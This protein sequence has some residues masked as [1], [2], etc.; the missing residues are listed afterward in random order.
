MGMEAGRDGYISAGG[1][2]SRRLLPQRYPDDVLV[3]ADWVRDRLELFADPA[4]DY[5][6]LEVDLNTAFYD[7]GH[8]P[9]ALSVDWT[10]DLQAEHC[11]DLVGPEAFGRLLG[12][13]GITEDT[14]VVVYGDN[15]NWFATHFHWI[16]S[17]YRHADVRVMDGGR[18]YWLE[19]DY[20]TSEAVPTVPAVDYEVRGRDES[21]R[22]YRDDVREALDTDTVFIDVRMPEEYRGDLTA[23]PGYNEAARRGG[24]IPGAVNVLWADNMR[25]DRQFKSPA[26]LRELYAEHG[27]GPDTDVI[28]YCR[29]GE[30][31]SVAWFALTQLLGYDSVRNYDGSWVEWGNMVGTPIERGN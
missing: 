4:A 6:L 16:S 7:R 20:P 28:T 10:E 26:D 14:T 29:I 12:E 11:R 13:R 5:R 24:H 15:A 8:V 31:S 22:A 25:P 23:P 27:I 3:T 17:Y 30:R 1:V 9:G 21:V 18:E 2:Y 19:N